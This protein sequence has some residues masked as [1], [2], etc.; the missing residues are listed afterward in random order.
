ME[1][2]VELID[3]VKSWYLQMH[4]NSQWI[5]I[6]CW[7]R[8]SS[9]TLAALSPPICGL[10]L[11]TLLFTSNERTFYCTQYVTRLM[12]FELQMLMCRFNESDVLMVEVA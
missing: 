8:N 2:H 5:H 10:F 1:Q 11:Y 6:V 4:Q 12:L 7:L 9:S 3:I